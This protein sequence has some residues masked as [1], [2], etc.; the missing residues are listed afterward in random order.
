MV[1]YEQTTP[2]SH[3]CQH[4]LDDAA[5]DDAVVC[6]H[7]AASTDA[8]Y[9]HHLFAND[10]CQADLGQNRASNFCHQRLAMATNGWSNMV[11]EELLPPTAGD[12][13]Q[14]PPMAANSWPNNG[15][16]NMAANS[17]HWSAG[18]T[19][20]HVTQPGRTN[21]VMSLMQR[22]GSGVTCGSTN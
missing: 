15:W 4:L 7:M 2:S 11:E 16:S 17:C 6:R 10:A 14:R 1:N 8:G 12:G 3:G 22:S 18:R 21:S 9:C 19:F 5:S 13:R 20:P